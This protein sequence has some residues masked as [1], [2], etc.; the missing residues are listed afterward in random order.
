MDIY[1]AEKRSAVMAAIRGKGN[2][3][4]ELHMAALLRSKSISGW[5]LHDRKLP[6]R[7]DF[8]FASRKLVVFVDGC[9]WHACGR[10]FRLPKKNRS[11]WRKKI[12]LNIKRDR[13]I[14][15]QLRKL[16]F[17]VVR[18]WEHEIEKRGSRV[19]ELLESL[20]LGSLST[21]L[22]SKSR[23]RRSGEL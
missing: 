19:Y 16:G 21:E 2:R 10:C 17:K 20:R 12:G 5:K 15:R 3:S 6:G 8:L 18:F 11:F 14:D 1:S 7:P 22:P 9:F 23:V 4:T 13:N